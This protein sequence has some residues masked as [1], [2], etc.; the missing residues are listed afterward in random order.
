MAVGVPFQ[1]PNLDEFRMI[2]IKYHGNAKA[3]AN[4]LNIIPHTLYSYFRR[5]PRAK[6]ILDEI[7]GYN[8]F[9][10]L[11]LAEYVNRYN[12]S[13]AKENPA[14]AQRAAEFTLKFKGKD[15]GWIDSETKELSSFDDNIGITLEN[16]KLRARIAE[17]ERIMNESKTGTE[18]ISSEQAPEYM[19]RSCEIGED[20][21]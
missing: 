14:V 10:D 20:L 2:C 8:S 5:D 12:L 1:P 9:T 4:H 3:I 19:V 13:Q 16:A 15:R 18:H 17:L 11:D 7:R 6:E 21:Q